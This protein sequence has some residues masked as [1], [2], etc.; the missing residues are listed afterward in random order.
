MEADRVWTWRKGSRKAGGRAL[1]A[2][3]ATWKGIRRNRGG[4][5]VATDEES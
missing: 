2:I 3:E 5:V 4:I 1:G